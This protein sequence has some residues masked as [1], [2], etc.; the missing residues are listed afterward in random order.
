MRNGRDGAGSPAHECADVG[1]EVID[2]EEQHVQRTL[3]RRG[4]KR[5]RT[6]ASERLSSSPPLRSRPSPIAL[7]LSLRSHSAPSRSLAPS[8]PR[9]RTRT[10]ISLRSLSR[11]LMSLFAPSS[12]IALVALIRSPS[13]RRRGRRPVRQRPAAA[14]ALRPVRG[15]PHDDGVVQ[16]AR[17]LFGLAVRRD[18]RQPGGARRL[19]RR[20]GR[21]AGRRHRRAGA[22]GQ[23]CGSTG[24]HRT[25]QRGWECG[26]GHREPSDRALG[27]A[28]SIE[29]A[30]LMLRYAC[31]FGQRQTPGLVVQSAGQRPSWAFAAPAEAATMRMTMWGVEC[32]IVLVPRRLA[33]WLSAI[34]FLSSGTALVDNQVFTG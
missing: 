30:P 32:T 24:G 3:L 31:C 19:V 9:A 18:V 10:H 23:Y 26:E 12:P 20:A 6:T 28:W 33:A 22:G 25:F 21:A 16:D 5:R 2:R 1:P 29:G 17:S 13:H 4:L 7:A 27:S 8:L 34:K 14:D 11:A 15:L